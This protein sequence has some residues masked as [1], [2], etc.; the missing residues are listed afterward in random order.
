MTGAPS[1]ELPLASA[2]PDKVAL[3]QAAVGDRWKVVPRDPGHAEAEAAVGYRE[4]AVAK[5][6]AVVERF[7]VPVALGHDSGFEFACL[8]GAP[9]PLTARWLASHGGVP[10]HDLVPGSEVTVVHCVA[11]VSRT[12]VLDAL[13]RDE[14][15][16][17]A[18]ATLDAG[19]LPLSSVTVGPVTALRRAVEEVLDGAGGRS[20]LAAAREVTRR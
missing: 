2:N 17:K 5:A 10:W 18:G 11:L 20:L 8:G 6:R 19:A 3:I 13:H 1:R 9:G 15:R 7:G 4:A 16:L 14:R 12:G